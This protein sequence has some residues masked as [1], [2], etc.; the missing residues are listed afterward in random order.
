M[1]LEGV[2]EFFAFLREGEFCEGEDLLW[3]LWALGFWEGFE[4]Y[5][6]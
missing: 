6:C 3:I 1:F 5:D 2:A 4:V